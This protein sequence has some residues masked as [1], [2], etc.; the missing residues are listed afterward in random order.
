M[1]DEGDADKTIDGKW[2]NIKTIIKETN[3]K[4]ME[5]DG[6]VERIRNKFYDEEMK[7]AVEMMEREMEMWQIK[8]KNRSNFI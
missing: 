1:E 7:A 4:I 3:Q 2:E 6:S 8:M 5:K